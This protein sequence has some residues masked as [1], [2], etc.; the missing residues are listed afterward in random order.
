M[1]FADLFRDVNFITIFSCLQ[2]QYEDVDHSGDWDAHSMSKCRSICGTN[3]EISSMA[4]FF[5]IH[6]RDPW[7]NC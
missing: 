5:P 7:P 4:I 3:L 2:N 6:A 1:W